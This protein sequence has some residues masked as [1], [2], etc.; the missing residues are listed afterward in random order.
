MW[1]SLPTLGQETYS[2]DSDTSLSP[3][4]SPSV[5]LS[6]HSP[7]HALVEHDDA[8]AVLLPDHLPEVTQSVLE[9]ALCTVTYSMIHT[10]WQE[11]AEREGGGGGE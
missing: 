3:S 11:R 2:V 9:W 10:I 1:V 8:G 6:Y 7:L 5:T 4:P